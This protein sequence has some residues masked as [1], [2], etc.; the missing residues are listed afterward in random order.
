MINWEDMYRK[1]DQLIA[2]QGQQWGR[3]AEGLRLHLGCGT[4][5][6]PGYTNVDLY[7]E[8]AEVHADVR[9]LDF[10]PGTAIEIVCHHVLEHLPVRDITPT[11]RHWY[12]LLAPGGTIEIGV[13]DLGL[14][15]EAFLAA[16]NQELKDLYRSTIYGDQTEEG[17]FHQAGFTL[18]EWIRV[19]EDV[20]FHMIEAYNYDGNGTPSAFMYATKPAS[21]SAS[22]LERDVV[23]GTFTHRTDYLPALWRSANE[24]LAQ[25]PFVTR[26][27]SGPINAGME[28]LRQD[29][30]KTGKRYWVFLDDDIQFLDGNII[31]DCVQAMIKNQWAVCHVHSSFDTGVLTRP[32]PDT[33]AMIGDQREH[34]ISW[35]TGYFIMVDSTKVGHIQ[36]DLQLPDPNTAVDTSY[37]VAIRALGHRIGI[38]PHV[39]YHFKKEGSWVNEDV[40]EPTNRYLQQK[41]G[42]FYFQNAVYQGNVLEW[43]KP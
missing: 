18:G 38:V 24:H 34:E 33:V 23:I 13:P 8:E 20:G 9:S 36:P 39:V 3:Q 11:L 14:C 10:E 37:S 26:H 22:L 4:L 16:P 30:I 28:L 12:D 1:R 25:I 41:W 27:H 6:L 40:I 2:W 29:F 15:M 21:S 19:V 5:L 17:R 7:T 42:D 31:R 35:A 43:P 32:Y